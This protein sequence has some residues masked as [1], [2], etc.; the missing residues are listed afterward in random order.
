MKRNI[1]VIVLS[2]LPLPYHKIGSWTNRYDHYI[3]N[4]TKIDAI[5][6]PK[7]VLEEYQKEY[8]FTKEPILHKINVKLKNDR[9]YHFIMSFSEYIAKYPKS[10]FVVQ[11]IDNFGL[12]KSLINYIIKHDL[13]NRIYLQYSYHGHELFANKE[14]TKFV[15]QHIN[16]ILF[17]TTSAVNANLEKFSVLPQ[18]VSISSNGID[19]SLFNTDKR[20][21]NADKTTFLWCSQ[22]RP[23][24]GLHII[25]DVWEKFHQN[26]PFTELLIV[27]TGNEIKAR[28]TKVIGK[29]EN[30]NLPNIYKRS[31]VYLFPTQWEEPFGLTLIEALHCGCFCIASKLGGVPEVLNNGEFGWLINKPENSENWYKAMVKYIEEKPT[32]NKI[33]VKKF[34]LEKWSQNMDSILEKAKKRL[35]TISK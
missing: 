30:K 5:I 27:G 16:E 28:G 29:V 34:N 14:D 2:H 10:S 6:C 8:L 20:I 21:N 19:T 22:D 18:Y 26:Y 9:F 7:P 35:E 32:L 11:I 24:K 4:S 3:K 17:L 33:P 23:K 25:L 31:D 15:F 13:R 1:K 12:V